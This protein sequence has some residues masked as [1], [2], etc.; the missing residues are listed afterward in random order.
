[1]KLT[2]EEEKRWNEGCIQRTTSDL[3]TCRIEFQSALER[4]IKLDD[5]SD[6]FEHMV[7]TYK[8]LQYYMSKADDDEKSTP[9]Y[10]IAEATVKEV[11]QIINDTL[12]KAYYTH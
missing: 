4:N 2:K 1:M 12:Q 8:I 7:A 10:E 9:I 11:K 3:V 6:D 5:L